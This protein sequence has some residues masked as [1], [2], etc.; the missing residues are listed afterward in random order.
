MRGARGTVWSARVFIT[1]VVSILRTEKIIF[2]GLSL[3][4]RENVLNSS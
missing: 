1:K 2:V 3:R 4:E